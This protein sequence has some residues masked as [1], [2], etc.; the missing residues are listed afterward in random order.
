MSAMN[1]STT[2][3]R[4]VEQTSTASASM[5]AVATTPDSPAAKTHARTAPSTKGVQ[6]SIVICTLDRPKGLRRA[7]RSCL[8]QDNPLDL[9]YEVVVVDNSRTANARDLVR[10]V[11]GNRTDL[12]RYLSDVRTNIVH[13]RNTG[14]AAAQG[15]CIAF[16]DDDMAAPPG[17]LSAAYASMQRTGADVPVGGIAAGSRALVWRDLALPDG[18]VIPP[19]RDGHIPHAG[20]DNCVFQR[21]TT[22]DGPAPFNPAFGRIGGED[23]DLLQRLNQ[24][25]AMAVFSKQAWMIEFIPAHRD[26]PEY[27]A[28][29]SYHTSQQF[30]RIAAQNGARKRL[31]AC[32]HMTTGLVQLAL[33][34]VRYGAAKM[35]GAGPVWARIAAAAAAGKLLWARCDPT[36]AAYR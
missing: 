9:T 24:R 20:T 11:S 10:R 23:T 12:V 25:G 6:L 15:H 31:T 14:V 32:R 4:W 21:A 5:V 18:A 29:R 30:V 36:C 17:W 8:E 22:I 34:I 7:L 13:A 16:M 26:T 35:V 33:A 2:P 19:K 27:L 28:R 1:S 3:R